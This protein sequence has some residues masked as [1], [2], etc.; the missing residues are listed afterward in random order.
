MYFGGNL[1]MLLPKTEK[2]DETVLWLN[3]NEFKSQY[4]YSNRFKI[5]HKQ[6]SSS[7]IKLELS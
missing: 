2:I 3:S 7:L 4:M 6:L 1:L 5:G